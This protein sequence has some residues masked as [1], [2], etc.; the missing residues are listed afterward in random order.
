MINVPE[1]KVILGELDLDIFKWPTLQWQ[2]FF[3]IVHGKNNLHL[4]I[5]H[6]LKQKSFLQA[7]ASHSSY[8][9]I[10]SQSPSTSQASLR[11][12]KRN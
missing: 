7:L 1:S 11:F 4:W 10:T 2:A 12:S 6:H 9:E 5:L 8:T 3:G